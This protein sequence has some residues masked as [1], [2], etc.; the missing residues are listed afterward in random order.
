MFSKLPW[1]FN[2]KWI[3]RSGPKRSVQDIP[4]VNNMRA[5]AS[6]A[7]VVILGAIVVIAANRLFLQPQGTGSSI[8]AVV[9]CPSDIPPGA[10]SSDNITVDLERR[11]ISYVCQDPSTTAASTFELSLDTDASTCKS[12]WLAA[13]LSDNQ[14]VARNAETIHERAKQD[15]DA[16]RNL[17]YW[18]TVGGRDLNGDGRVAAGPAFSVGATIVPADALGLKSLERVTF[19]GPGEPKVVT[20]GME[21]FSAITRLLAEPLQII[22]L[23]NRPADAIRVEFATKELNAFG[24]LTYTVEYSPSGGTIGAYDAQKGVRVSP[25]IAQVLTHLLK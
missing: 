23:S 17:E 18:E 5:W 16:G 10:T 6:A 2:P 25:A 20:E 7:A 4:R 13:T 11:V 24:V 21:E 22:E 3:S 12:Q 14:Q 9:Q 19:F 1:L 8:A 15:I